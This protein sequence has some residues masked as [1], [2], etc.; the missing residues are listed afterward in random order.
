MIE[1]SRD[2]VAHACNPST[3]GGRGGWITRS[4]DQD[5]PDQHGETPCLLKIQK[6]ISWVW[7][8]MPVV[9]ATQ[10]AEAEEL[11]EPRRR[12]LQ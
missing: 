11:L 1:I 3:L 6:K 9:P 8:H 2:S 7:W 12:R 5:Q 4:R 10:E